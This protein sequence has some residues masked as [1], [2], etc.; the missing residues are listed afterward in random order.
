MDSSSIGTLLAAPPRN[1]GIPL[2]L[3]WVAEAAA[4]RSAIDRRAATIPARRS[5]KKTH[6]AAWLVR[7]IEC[8]DL[9]TLAGDD[10][11]GNVSRLCSKALHPIRSDL[12]EALGLESLHVGA[13][14][15]YHQR[16]A[17]AAKALGGT[18]I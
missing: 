1:P 5:V 12:L 13:V 7:A 17:D 14:C 16:V 10:T 3:D 18:D 11:A 2:D 9:T 6:Q 8:I 15:V 4:N